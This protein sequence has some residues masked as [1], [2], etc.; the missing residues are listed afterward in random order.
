[1]VPPRSPSFLV[2]GCLLSANV[3]VSQRVSDLFRE[4]DSD[5]S[6]SITTLELSKGL[7]SLLGPSAHVRAQAKLAAKKEATAAAEAEERERRRRKI[8][9]RVTKAKKSG[10]LDVILRVDKFMHAKG[11]RIRDLFTQCGFDQDGDGR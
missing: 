10:A 3:R 9:A 8:L 7:V 2:L 5:G 11:L 4:L 1:M 6:G